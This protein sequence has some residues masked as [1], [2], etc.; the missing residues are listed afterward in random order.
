MR[1]FVIILPIFLIFNRIEAQTNMEF[2]LKEEASSYLFFYEV[3]GGKEYFKDSIWLDESGRGR[4]FT[5]KKQTEGVYLL[6]NSNGK[7]TSVLF[8]DDQDFALHGKSL[9]E[10][11]FVGSEENELYNQHVR[12][13]VTFYHKRDSLQHAMQLV[14]DDDAEELAV[15]VND[16]FLEFKK[17]EAVRKKK[18]G[19]YFFSRLLDANSLV[20]LPDSLLSATQEQV[21]RYYLHHFLESVDFTDSRLLQ[22]SVFHKQLDTYFARVVAPVPDSLVYYA[23]YWTERLQEFPDFQQY[24]VNF[25]L[26]SGEFSNRIGA[27]NVFVVLVEKYVT[28]NRFSWMNESLQKTLIYRAERKRT[29]MIGVQAP[30][31]FLETE[32]GVELSLQDITSKIVVLVFWSPDCVHCTEA[33]PT[34]K[35]AY[36]AFSREEMELIAINTGQDEQR[37]HDFVFTKQFPWINAHDTNNNS[38]FREAYN[39]FS[40]PSIFILDKERKIILKDIGAENLL[41][42]LKISVEQY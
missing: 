31:L 8:T 1:L 39:I 40:T 14:D 42:A 13:T 24:L 12:T 4:F 9:V 5:Q 22:S 27:E 15:E 17:H 25:L 33:L 10:F 3:Y 32:K 19:A 7:R 23:C 18:Y 2:A 35:K 41:M 21:H 28:T 6:A 36:S 20:A 29:S 30:P 11:S 38:N 16:L 37:W 26:Q 34:I